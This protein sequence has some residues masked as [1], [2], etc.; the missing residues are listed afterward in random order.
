MK[1]I[2]RLFAKLVTK[3]REHCA[4]VAQLRVERAEARK[5]VAEAKLE[6]SYA[7]SDPECSDTHLRNGLRWLDKAIDEYDE[8]CILDK[9]R[10]Y[11]G[12]ASFTGKVIMAAPAV[13]LLTL[14]IVFVGDRIA[15]AFDFVSFSTQYNLVMLGTFFVLAIPAAISIDSGFVY[16]IRMKI[17]IARLKAIRKSIA[18]TK[19]LIEFT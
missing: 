17:K 19:F 9:S 1:A 8:A 16:K 15:S 13:L 2:K 10:S 6:F 7:N 5:Y 11:L 12:S 18:N 14:L 3:Y 4:E